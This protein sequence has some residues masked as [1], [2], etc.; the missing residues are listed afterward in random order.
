MKALTVPVV[1][2]A[3]SW[4]GTAQIGCTAQLQ[5]LKPLT[6]L[7]CT[8]TSLAC[9]CDPAG[10]SCHWAWACM[11]SSANDSTW[12]PATPQM[13]CA[14]Q[15]QP[16]KPLTP[17]GCADTSPACLCNPAGTSCYRAWACVPFGDPSSATGSSAIPLMVRPP[18]AADPLEFMLQIQQLRALQQQMS[19]TPPPVGLRPQTSD[20]AAEL[21]AEL[22]MMQ[23]T[24]RVP[25]SKADKKL[26]R[27]LRKEEAKQRKDEA[28][29]RRKEGSK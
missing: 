5:P 8:D 29:Q 28:A 4:P 16:L 11:Q 27:I 9:L 15:L 21:E 12:Q 6:P 22:A 18:Q 3:Y 1:L 13:G 24:E 7:G 23:E 14:A 19:A 25:G 17:L 26:A 2:L 10:T 20:D